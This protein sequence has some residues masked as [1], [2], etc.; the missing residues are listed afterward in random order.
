DSI[1]P[2]GRFLN[3]VMAEPLSVSTNSLNFTAPRHSGSPGRYLCGW[4]SL[5]SIE[6]KDD[7]GD[8]SVSL[9]GKR[10]PASCRDSFRLSILCFR[11][12]VVEC[13]TSTVVGVVMS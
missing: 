10:K 9:M 7:D 4:L 11:D 5:G 3:H 2:S 12:M 8:A 13:A 6:R 1:D